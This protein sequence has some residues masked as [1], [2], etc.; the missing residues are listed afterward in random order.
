MHRRL[1]VLAFGFACTGSRRMP[2]TDASTSEDGIYEYSA[3]IP[4]FQ[5]GKTIRVRG[6]L[7]VVG[8]S[9]F[10]QPDSGCAVYRPTTA[11]QKPMPGIVSLTCGEAGLNFDRRNLKSGRW[12]SYVQVPKQRNVCVQYEPRDPART[13]RCLRSRPETYY[14]RQPRSG[15][16][17]IKPIQ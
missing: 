1:M 12:Y 14:E 15:V 9:L 13:Q 5:I 17:Q 2:A 11:T 10:V 3:S 6:S 8:D 7:T 16:V 4:A